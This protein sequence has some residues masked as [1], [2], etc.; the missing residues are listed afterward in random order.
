MRRA[1]AVQ[2]V[3]GLVDGAVEILWVGKGLL[4]NHLDSA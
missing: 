1:F 3:N 4:V 2:C